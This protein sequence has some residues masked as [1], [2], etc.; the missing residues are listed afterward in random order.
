MRSYFRLTLLVAALALF[1]PMAA[2]A[3]DKVAPSLSPDSNAASPDMLDEMV[4]FAA[5]SKNT[6]KNKSI[7]MS[8]DQ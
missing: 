2:S 8:H 5:I 4:V 1:H 3:N 6:D 7:F